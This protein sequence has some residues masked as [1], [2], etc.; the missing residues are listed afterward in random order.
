MQPGNL[1]RIK[2]ATIG[3][4]PDSLALIIERRGARSPRDRIEI[5]V[6]R[7]V[8]GKGK[9]ARMRRYLARDLKVIS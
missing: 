9:A 3:V 6:V 4:P 2:R 5:Y 7:L 1:V 8:G